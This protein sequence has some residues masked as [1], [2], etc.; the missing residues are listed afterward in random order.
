MPPGPAT[1]S[2]A[3]PGPQ[4]PD[5]RGA[6]REDAMRGLGFVCRCGFLTPDLGAF[7]EHQGEAHG[8]DRWGGASAARAA[9][10][11]DAEAARQR[12]RRERERAATAL[13]D[14]LARARATARARADPASV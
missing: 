5:R 1:G 10:V 8:D 7:L 3:P 13:A 14:A 12:Q 4:A 11:R 9:E 6:K 2:A